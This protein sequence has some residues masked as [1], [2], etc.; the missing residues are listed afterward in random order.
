MKLELMTL[1]LEN[2]KGIAALEIAFDGCSAAIYGENA[3]GKST[4]YDALTWLLFGKDSR[5]RKDFDIKPLDENGQVKDHGAVTAVEAVLRLDGTERKLRRTYYE[6]WSTR[7]GSSQAAFDGHSS[8]YFVD[9]VPCKKLEFSRRVG[10]MVDESVFRLLT[11]ITYFPAELPWQERRAALFDLA[12]VAGD[13][14]IMAGDGRFEPLLDAL[15]GGTLD[16]LRKKLAARRRQLNGVRNDT[17]ARLDECR[18][19]AE[20]CA[21]LDFPALEAEMLACLERRDQ[22]RRALDRTEAGERAELVNRLAEVKNRLDRL[23]NE[24]AAYRMEQRQESGQD[25]MERLRRQ[26]EDLRN[27]R[28]SRVRHLEGLRREQRRLEGRVADC[29]KQW[30]AANRERFTGG[31]CPTCGQALPGDQLEKARVAFEAGKAQKKQEAVAAANSAKAELKEVLADIQAQES[32]E[33]GDHSAAMELET[34]LAELEA[35]PRAEVAD[36]EGYAEQRAELE[37]RKAEL[38]AALAALDR[39]AAQAR[40]QAQGSLD[41]A[42]R[43]LDRVNG[44]LAQKVTLAHARE[45][46]RQLRDQAGKAEKELAEVDGLLGLC[47]E[48]LRYKAR[49]VEESVNGRFELVRFR[50]FKEQINGGLEDC[51]DVTVGGVPY[52]SLN[53]GARIN[54]GIDIINALSRHYGVQVPLFIDNA[55]SVTTLAAADT[56]VI[57]LVAAEGETELRVERECQCH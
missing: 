49:K 52:A 36:L 47:D 24:N 5:G 1:R 35:A 28:A 30:D 7:R 46:E 45:R 18:R 23:E 56:Q 31:T 6:V 20:G 38:S 25:E 27:R 12:A 3:A 29:R 32:A 14:E 37:R 15:G 13:R 26:L 10:E 43:A 42:N 16:D 34:R 21:G 50:L 2:F 19:T 22:A 55:E 57:R 40:R 54:A 33:N 39:D 17:P 4:V 48:F 53:T 11:S 51:C 44:L 8:D 41:E 9:G